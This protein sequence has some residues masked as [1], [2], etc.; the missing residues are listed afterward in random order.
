LLVAGFSVNKRLGEFA[1]GKIAWAKTLR[2][3]TPLG[4]RLL[5]NSQ[6]GI[7]A[8]EFL[9][10]NGADPQ[11]TMRFLGRKRSAVGAAKFLRWAWAKMAKSKEERERFTAVYDTMIRL[12]E[13]PPRPVSDS[14]YGVLATPDSEAALA[15]VLEQYGLDVGMYGSSGAKTIAQLLQELRAGESTL[16]VS[17][18]A[19]L[20]IT[21]PVFITLRYTDAGDT[22]YVVEKEQTF[23]DG[24]VRP[25]TM[26]VAEKKKAG[27]AWVD[28]AVRGIDEELGVCGSVLLE[29]HVMFTE[30]K[31]SLSYPGLL[32]R[33]ITHGV[34]VDLSPSDGSK[35]GLPGFQPFETVEMKGSDG[36]RHLW[37]WWTRDKC[38][39]LVGFSD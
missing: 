8:V 19:L 9:L 18:S 13:N 16:A 22:R 32:S 10:Q 37:E 39:S 3:W 12:L 4:V 26:L 1:D 36:L 17:A 31:R 20:R 27:E 21:E 15:T 30:E 28:C 33:Y 25:R 5:D 35:L 38:A 6:G 23:A 2:D 24:R 29:S 7:D 14:Q 34:T 11:V